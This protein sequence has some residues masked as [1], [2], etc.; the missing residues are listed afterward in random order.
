MPRPILARPAAREPT[1]YAV[2]ER[3]MPAPVELEHEI[4][5]HQST[6]EGLEVGRRALVEH[7][8]ER[9]RESADEHWVVDRPVEVG[10]STNL[11][12]VLHRVRRGRSAQR[13]PER[14]DPGEIE[15]TAQH[16][17]SAIQ[18]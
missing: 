11:G 18:L 8:H 6:Y 10:A 17:I 5:P 15:R 1:P 9:S 12:V 2:R 13:E 7:D 16:R 14:P 4:R 3:I